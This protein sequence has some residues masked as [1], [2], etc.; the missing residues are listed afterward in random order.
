MRGLAYFKKRDIHFTKDLPEP[1]I[2]VDDEIIIDVSYCGICGSDLHEYLEGPI[3]MPKDNE[4]NEISNLSLPLAMGHEMSGIVREVGKNVT[5]V[6]KGDKVVVEASSACSDVHRFAT[7]KHYGE[8]KCP[9]CARGYDNCCAYAGFTGLGFI[10]GG[11]AEQILVGE[12]HIVRIPDE[13]PLDVAALVE[14]LSVTW[15]AAKVGKFV[16][17]STALILGSGPIGLAMILVLKAL[18]ASKIVVSEVAQVRRKL[19]EKMKVEVFDPSVHGKNTSNELR[20]LTENKD[21]FDFAFDC[22]GLEVTMNTAIHATKCRGT[23]VNVAVWGSTME[24][25]MMD[26]TLQEKTLI[27]SIGYVV[28]DFE[29]VVA[30][31]HKRAI[32]IEDCRHL[33]TGKQKIEDGW[34]HGFMELMNH[35]EKNIKI[36]LTPNNYHELD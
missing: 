21:G 7:G 30:S 6:K 10:G 11:F 28:R 29:E 4:T 1:K 9:N 33:I 24:F 25:N 13:I 23:I 2:N 19:A 17:G 35:K 31:I 8:E 15:H 34:E 16:K 26:I 32:S 3:F 22:S 5:K 18:G 12:Q 27:G 14:P 20:L 36:L